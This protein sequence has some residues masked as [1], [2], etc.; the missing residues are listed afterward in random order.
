MANEPTNGNGHSGAPVARLVLDFDMLAG[1]LSITGSVP[2]EDVALDM[3]A[4]ATRHYEGVVRFQQ[5]L[6]YTRQQQAAQRT[7]EILS[8]VR[9]G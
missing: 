2:N 7:N 9:G 3:L 4:R 1:R 8:R 6:E 5:I